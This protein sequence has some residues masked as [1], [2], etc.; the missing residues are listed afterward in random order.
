MGMA[1][2]SADGRRADS[3]WER[4][5]PERLLFCGVLNGLENDCERRLSCSTV[6][7]GIKLCSTP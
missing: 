3:R 1:T 6:V 5:L 7:G 4:G 2:S